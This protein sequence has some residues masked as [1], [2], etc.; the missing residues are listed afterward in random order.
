M[1]SNN[2]FSVAV[3]ATLIA[4]LSTAASAQ[5][6]DT[7]NGWYGN[8]GIGACYHLGELTDPGAAHPELNWFEAT[9]YCE[10]QIPGKSFLATIRNQARGN[11]FSS[12]CLINSYPLL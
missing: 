1:K 8:E 11:L 4:A 5:E 7:A 3:C 10:A 6:C 9:K 2:S 12:F